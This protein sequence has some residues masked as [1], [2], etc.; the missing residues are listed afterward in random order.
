MNKRY[1]IIGAGNGGQSLAGDMVLRNAPLSAIY[2]IDDTAIK[3][4]KKRGGIEMSGP[5]VEGFAEIALATSNL[6]EAIAAGDVF[7]VCVTAQ[8]Y[9]KFARQAAPFVKK[10]HT[11]L[12]IP[13][14][15]GSSLMFS[16]VLE[17]NGVKELPLIGETASFP[18]ATRLIEPAHAG[19]KARKAVL[20]IAAYPASRNQELFEIVK[21]AIFEAVLGQDSL[22]VGCNNVNPASH[23]VPY[24][25]NMDKVEMPRP[26][27]FN[28]HAW[29]SKT[30]RKIKLRLD[31]ERC[32]IMKAIG[33]EAI[34][35]KEFMQMSYKGEGYKPIPQKTSDLPP[36]A[37]QVPDRFIDEDIPMGVVPIVDF[38]RLMG[39]P[40]PVSDVM[41]K[42][43]GLV[44]DR[45][46]AAEGTTLEKM[47]LAG[48]STSEILEKL[49]TGKTPVKGE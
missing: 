26:E 12:L 6:E 4:I 5:V 11:Y 3:S 41:I 28:F 23:V 35:Y 46:F 22:S 39:I 34:T 16:K 33:L 17:D 2:D 45:D 36:S 18:Y 1:V 13:G 9:A 21:P 24:L 10:N 43:A 25:M 31:E 42:L 44:R 29:G 8:A 38:G 19:I 14:Y 49:K 40:T 7:F 15:A 20:H 37:G 32:T 48:L 27:D 30:V 47:G